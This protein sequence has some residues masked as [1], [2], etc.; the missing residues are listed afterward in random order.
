MGLVRLVSA[1]LIFQTGSEFMKDPKN[2]EDVSVAG[3]EIMT[4]L[5][6]WGHDKFMGVPQNTTQVQ[7]KKSARQ[8]YAEA[9]MEDDSLLMGGGNRRMYQYDDVQEPGEE[10]TPDSEETQQEVDLDADQEAEKE[11]KI[12]SLDDLLGGDDEEE[13]AATSDL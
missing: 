12:I 1:F 6:E 4:E 3:S 8:I 9:F 13:D 5:Y 7:L 10:K 2:W 11:P